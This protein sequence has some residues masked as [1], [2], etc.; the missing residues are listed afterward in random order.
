MSTPQPTYTAEHCRAAYQLNWSLSVFWRQ[1]APPDQQWLDALSQSTERDDVRILEHEFSQENVS[2]FLLS[3]TAS[4]A[5][6][7]AVRS[8]KG[9]LQ[10][11]V[12]AE[13][14]MAFR[15]NY[16]IHSTGSAN[17]E[18][19]E[20]YVASQIER[21]PMADPRI[22]DRLRRFQVHE[23]N[24]DLSAVRDSAHGQF[25]HN[26]HLVLVY[27]DRGVYMS[28]E[29]LTVTIDTLRRTAEKK[30]HLLCRAS[31][32]ADHLHFALGCDVTES[33]QEVA[34]SYMNNLAFMHGGARVFEDSYYV[35][36]FGRFDLNATRH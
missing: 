23:P 18:T 19:V 36:T 12:Q 1:A 8:I 3:T 26:L 13:Q 11:R 28:E 4:V 17:T 32:V 24:V 34:L 21:H 10:H 27:R 14:P 5:P 16:A 25:L 22:V 2:Q 31:P 6:A 35:G 7:A 15:R 33:P 9:R 29:W 30:G 20:Q